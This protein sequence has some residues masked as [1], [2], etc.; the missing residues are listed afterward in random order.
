MAD[1]DGVGC[2]VALVLGGGTLAILYGVASYLQGTVDPATLVAAL[3]A[4]WTV[5]PFV[6]ISGA[7][8]IG[9]VLMMFALGGVYFKDWWN[10]PNWED[11]KW[12]R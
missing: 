2:V 9:F 3:Y 5:A 1:N 12:D 4:T 6:I 7:I 10:R 8:S 11:P